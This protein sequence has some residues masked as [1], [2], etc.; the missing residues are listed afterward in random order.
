MTSKASREY[1]LEMALK[2]PKAAFNL[3]FLSTADN[4]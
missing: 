2:P 3:S 1:A 4:L